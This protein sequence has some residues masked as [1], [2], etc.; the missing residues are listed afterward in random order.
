MSI[1]GCYAKL[2]IEDTIQVT[3]YVAQLLMSYQKS[4]TTDIQVGFNFPGVDSV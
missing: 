1:L 3:H 4:H 2:V